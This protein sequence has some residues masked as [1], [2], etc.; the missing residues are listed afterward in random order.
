MTSRLDQTH[1]E[2]GYTYTY[3]EFVVDWC[4]PASP[5]GL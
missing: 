4:E 1:E 2:D 5:L 3:D